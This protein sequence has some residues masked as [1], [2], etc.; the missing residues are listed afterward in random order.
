MAHDDYPHLVLEWLQPDSAQ[1][2]RFLPLWGALRAE[3]APILGDSGFSAL[4]LRSMHLNGGLFPWLPALAV[5]DARGT[6]FSQLV[7]MLA[8]KLGEQAPADELA[9]SRALFVSFYD[10]LLT[11]IGAPLA[12]GALDA[13]WGRPGFSHAA[14]PAPCHRE[15]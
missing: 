12:A 13:A 14:S 4:F 1:S 3:L 2:C 6:D 10:E 5:S 15:I 11:L 8:G 7:V 9:A